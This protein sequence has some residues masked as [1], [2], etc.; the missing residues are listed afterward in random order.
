MSKEGSIKNQPNQEIPMTNQDERRIRDKWLKWAR[1]QCDGKIKEFAACE[2]E[3]P[4]L[5]FMKCKQEW[6]NMN[7]CTRQ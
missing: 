6:K 4:V 1:K 2:K 7:A 5:A 3:H